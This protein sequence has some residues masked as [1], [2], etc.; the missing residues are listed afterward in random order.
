MILYIS[1]FECT[2]VIG[3]GSSNGEWF[4]VGDR[5]RFEV[6]S[7]SDDMELSLVD[8]SARIGEDRLEFQVEGA[9]YPLVRTR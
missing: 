4:T 1:S 3:N 2:G 9:S 8:A 6:V 7:E 5:V